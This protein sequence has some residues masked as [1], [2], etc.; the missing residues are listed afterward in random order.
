MRQKFPI[1]L[2]VLIFVLTGVV[3]MLVLSVNEGTENNVEPQLLVDRGKDVLTVEKE[4]A[5]DKDDVVQPSRINPEIRYVGPRENI[6]KDAPAAYGFWSFAMPVSGVLSRS[7]QPLIGEFEWLKENGWK[8]VVNLRVDGERDEVGDDAKI[9][10]FTE[11]G[12]N[13]LHIPLVDGHPPTNEQA[14]QFLAFVN[15][16]QNQPAHVHCRGGIGRAGIMTALYRYAVQ[17]WPLE[18]AI[19][20]SRPFK[21]GISELQRAWLEKW[22]KKHPPGS[23]VVPK[24]A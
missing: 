17:S 13:Y 7:G 2:T 19:E 12:L 16:P 11:L 23:H 21:G 24:G 20:E 1:L 4:L 18:K 6:P 3:V 15:D 5:Y 9:P 14:E 8:G 10:G 22:S